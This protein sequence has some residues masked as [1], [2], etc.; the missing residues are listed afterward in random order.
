L[1]LR[2]LLLHPGKEN[3]GRQANIVFLLIR[4]LS[5]IVFVFVVRIELHVLANRKQTARV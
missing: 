4:S 5:R 1:D 2:G 3:V